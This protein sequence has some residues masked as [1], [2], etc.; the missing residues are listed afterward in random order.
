MDPAIRV[1]RLGGAGRI[2]AET[3]CLEVERLK[4]EGGSRRRGLEVKVVPG[5][6]GK[7]GIG[8]PG[9]RIEPESLPFRKGAPAEARPQRFRCVPIQI[10]I[11]VSQRFAGGK[12]LVQG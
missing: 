1:A 6:I 4:T 2:A 10:V 9:V 8:D 11:P 7:E 5:G 12:A 3:G